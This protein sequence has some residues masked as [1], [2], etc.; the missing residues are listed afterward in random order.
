MRRTRGLWMGVL[1]VVLV[2][3]GWRAVRYHQWQ[4]QVSRR[5]DAASPLCW[6]DCDGCAMRVNGTTP[7]RRLPHL[8]MPLAF[9]GDDVLC[10]SESARC[11]RVF[12]PCGLARTIRWTPPPG[13]TVRTISPTAQGALLNLDDTRTSS[14]A[15]VV[16]VDFTTGT[17]TRL[18]DILQAR[19]S[20]DSATIA[21][22]TTHGTLEWRTGARRERIPLQLPSVAWDVDP[23]H[24]LVFINTGLVLQ[25]FSP[26]G[27]RRWQ[28]RHPHAATTLA[29]QPRQRQ[30]WIAEQ[31]GA[32]TVPPIRRIVAYSYDG[33]L[34]GTRADIDLMPPDMP[35]TNATPRLL[36]AL[37]RAETAG[38]EQQ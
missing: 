24:R 20:A 23:S 29:V 28:A 10:W 35:M 12:S 36:Q 1:L 25:A 3:I 33:T 5:V 7:V 8:I 11:L 9:R 18:A 31:S 4:V 14:S 32:F 38:S 21:V 13:L 30:V 17:V 26:T 34:L 19:G 2:G 16:S 15:G 37:E 22:C 6:L 27:Q